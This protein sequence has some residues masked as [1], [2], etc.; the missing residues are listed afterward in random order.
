MEENLNKVCSDCGKQDETVKERP[1]GY[2]L[3][4][5]D[6]YKSDMDFEADYD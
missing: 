2:G 4:C 5:Y 6:C 1:D 3:Q